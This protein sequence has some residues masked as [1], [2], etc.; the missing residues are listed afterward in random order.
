M[1]RSQDLSLDYN[2][3]DPIGATAITQSFN[4]TLSQTLDNLAP[5]FNIHLFLVDKFE[6]L[7]ELSNGQ[8]DD[9]CNDFTTPLS[10]VINPV[11][12]DEYFF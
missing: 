12:P 11:S 5:Y 10:G 6:A 8:N 1:A 7:Q 9:G 3:P 4:T 2:T